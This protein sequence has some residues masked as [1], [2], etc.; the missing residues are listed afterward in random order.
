MINRSHT[1]G[2]APSSGVCRDS[3]GAQGAFRDTPLDRDR[4]NLRWCRDYS[5]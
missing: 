1:K 2:G 5:L 3:D 4:G